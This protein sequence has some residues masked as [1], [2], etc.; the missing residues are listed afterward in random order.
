MIFGTKIQ[1][2]GL[3]GRGKNQKTINK[4]TFF[5]LGFLNHFLRFGWHRNYSIVWK[6]NPG[7]LT[8]FLGFGIFLGRIFG[9]F[10]RILGVIFGGFLEAF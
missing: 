6:Q 9:D 4:K 2:T 5:F 8:R 7:F 1:C 3:S 10:W